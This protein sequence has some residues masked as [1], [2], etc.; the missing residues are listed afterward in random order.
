MGDAIKKYFSFRFD[1]KQDTGFAIGTLLLFWLVYFLGS[2]FDGRVFTLLNRE[3]EADILWFIF[4][5]IMGSL[6]LGVYLPTS[7]VT[8]ELNQRINHLGIKKQHLWISLGISVLISLYYLPRL[9]ALIPQVEVS[10]LIRHLLLNLSGLWEV[11]F[12]YGWLQLRY[13]RAFGPIPAV[14]LSA[15][16]FTLYH[17]GTGDTLPITTLLIIGLGQ[18]FAFSLTKNIFILWPIPW[19][20]AYSVA[21]LEA[22]LTFPWGRVILFLVFLGV[23][24]ATVEWVYE[25]AKKEIKKIESPD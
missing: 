12:V 10:E 22:G 15:L 11:I 21:S 2:F 17:V 1:P 7:Y 3:F 9:I 19:T 16:S 18:A 8:K 14:A 24:Y 4:A 25:E 13:D 5:V 23:Y 6:F 20:V